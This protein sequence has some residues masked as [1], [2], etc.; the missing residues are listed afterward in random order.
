M[1][2]GLSIRGLSKSFFGVPVLRDLGLDIVPGE[3][4]GLVGANGAGKSTLMNILGGHLSADSGTIELDGKAYQPRSSREAL[5]Q[6]IG[7]VHQE[8]NLFSNLTIAENLFL[9]GGKNHYGWINRKARDRRVQECLQ[10]VG[11]SLSPS[12]KVANLS[13]GQ[14]QLVELARLLASDCQ[15]LL[16]DEPTTSLSDREAQRF[17][18]I[19]HQLSQSGKSIVL[20]THAIDDVV[21]HC[22]RIAILRDGTL[23]ENILAE[24]IDS[25]GV[26]RKMIGRSLGQLFPDKTTAADPA[27][28]VLLHVD[29]LSQPQVV[30]NIDFEVHRGETVG[31]F[32][33]MGA[34]RSELARILIGIDPCRSGSVTLCGQP[35][36]HGPRSRIHRGLGMITEDRRRDGILAN[37]SVANN[38]SLVAQRNFASGWL[39]WIQQPR[40]KAALHTMRTSV[41]LQGRLSDQQPMKTLSG[42]N[43]QKAILGK[44]LLEKSRVLILDEPTRGIDVGAR[45]EVYK[46]IERYVQSGNGALVISSDLDE[47]I[48][49]CDRILVMS[50]GRIVARF[51]RSDYDRATILQAAFQEHLRSV[52]EKV[53]R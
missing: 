53:N 37:S 52:A 7:Q 48:G 34:G 29:R 5:S 31:I 41:Y 38:L 45:F 26:I 4:L 1:S 6:G 14:Q 15:V 12:T 3:I 47:L 8:L 2:S 11:L 50:L 17:F 43:Q 30:S 23:V 39:Q 28:E 18:E 46:L 22:H 21:K 10:R 36:K 42:G 20:I 40:L 25:K 9:T 24:A 49:I 13:V 35:L 33:L 51:D 27:E 44:W 32:G 16:L 19:I